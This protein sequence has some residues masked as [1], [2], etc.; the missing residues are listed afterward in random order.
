MAG[1]R[2]KHPFLSPQSDD[3]KNDLQSF[4]QNRL[5]GRE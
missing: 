4:Q 5:E 1:C 2:G 3:H